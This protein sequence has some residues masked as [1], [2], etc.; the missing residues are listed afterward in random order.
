M[1]SI[2]RYYF[3]LHQGKNK[4]P[5]H[6]E[7]DFNRYPLEEIKIAIMTLQTIFFDKYIL[8]SKNDDFEENNSYQEGS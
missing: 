2:S 5:K 8:V 1:K 6:F 4:N 3:F 7:I